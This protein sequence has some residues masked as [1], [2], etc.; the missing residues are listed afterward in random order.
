MTKRLLCFNVHYSPNSFGGATVVAEEVNQWLVKKHGWTVCVVTTERNKELL[1]YHISR[2][3]SKL[4]N[5]ISINLPSNVDEIT[6]LEHSQFGRVV[7]Q[8]VDVF[9]PTMVH[10]HAI[11]T[12]GVFMIDALAK[13]QIPLVATLHDCWWICEKQFMINAHGK[14]CFQTT[15]EKSVCSYCVDDKVYLDKRWSTLREAVNKLDLCLF[16]SAFHM[17]LHILN[18]IDPSRC[19]VNYNGIKFPSDHYAKK[20]KDKVVFAFIGGPG[21]IKGGELIAEVFENLP[22]NYELRLVNAAQNVGSDWSADFAGLLKNPKV[23]L[24]NAYTQ[25]KM[26]DFFAEVDVLLFP[27]QWKESFGLTVREALIR[28]I[29]IICTDS[30]GTIENITDGVNGDIIPLTSNVVYLR[31]KVLKA[32]SREWSEY[33]NVN[34]DGIRTYEQQAD[35]LDTMLNR[36]WQTESEVVA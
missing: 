30:G 13:R 22:G 3:K 36:L 31:D 2:Y 21:S 35:E 23:K 27:S 20:S 9:E 5:V 26:D 8:I 24:V 33:R 32:I 25:E 6:L 16:P 28:D 29:W 11:Q 7:E 15:I 17:Q 4:V 19:A 12:M 1:P 10:F 18:G 34:K 14:Y